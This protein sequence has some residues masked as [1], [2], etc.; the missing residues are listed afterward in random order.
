M[1]MSEL[2][3]LDLTRIFDRQQ[4]LAAGYND[5]EIR[6]RVRTGVWRRVR[7]GIYVD[8]K[9]YDSLDEA[10]AHK[11][12]VEAALRKVA[13]PAVASH[14]SA[15]VV[16]GLEM[17][18]PDLSVVHLTRPGRHAP[19]VEA[20]IHHH[21]GTFDF[22]NVPTVGGIPVTPL[23]R[24]VVDIALH[25]PFEA[26][27]VVADSAL[28]RG[29]SREELLAE[30]ESCRTWVGSRDASRVVAFADGRAESVAESRARVAF[31]ELQLPPPE[32][33]AEFHDSNGKLLART[34]FYFPDQRTVVEF[35]GKV[36]YVG[37]AGTDTGDVLWREK[38]REDLLRE[39]FAVEFVRMDWQDLQPDRRP[40]L[41]K[42]IRAAFRRGEKLRRA[43]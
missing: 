28:R 42:R 13:P 16:H 35:D 5:D 29:A 23:P 33:Q 40:A 37:T 2:V 25:A 38:Q 20:G 34:D 39:M 8:G 41:A 17:Y 10:G 36:K 18:D 22:G 14:W 27:V 30:L 32:L 21:V 9:L 11:L 43:A 12:E 26:A 3:P 31:F 4:A 15:A 7:R 19:R 24:T 1:A 6:N